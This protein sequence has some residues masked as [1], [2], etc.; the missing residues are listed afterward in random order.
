MP[1]QLAAAPPGAYLGTYAADAPNT[2]LIRPRI[3]QVI[4]TK[5]AAHLV[6]R[7]SMAPA[8]A[9][10]ELVGMFAADGVLE[11]CADGL[12]WLRV[13]CTA[14]GGAGDLAALPAVAQHFH[15]LY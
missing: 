15:L 14:H 8:T 13:A 1:D 4:P 12:A 6:H 2:E 5:Y 10:Q 7:E 11:V 9:Y 3:T